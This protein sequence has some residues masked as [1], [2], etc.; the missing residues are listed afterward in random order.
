[1]AQRIY[2]NGGDM[3][4]KE[5]SGKTADDLFVLQRLDKGSSI[6]FL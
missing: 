1:M 4:G 5:Q 3:L 2:L 6:L